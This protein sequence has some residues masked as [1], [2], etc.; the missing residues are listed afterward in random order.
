MNVPGR[1]QV[2]SAFDELAGRLDQAARVY[3]RRHRLPPE[4][5]DD[6]LQ[7]TL[8]AF[9]CKHEEIRDPEAWLRGTLRKR[10]QLYWR[11]RQRS[12]LTMVDRSVLEAL[13]TRDSGQEVEDVGR[14]L[15]RALDRIP[16]RCRRLLELR[17]RD[18]C[19]PRDAAKQLGYRP[20]GVY[21]IM[22]RCLAALTRGLVATG[23]MREGAG[24]P[25]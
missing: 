4:D 2:E 8:L 3:L 17:Y 23:F 18:D 21:K 1:P 15:D 22:A 12:L 10:C 25:S 19:D 16:V 13:A 9:L 14:D 20:S 5:A 7:E 6:I 24:A 11:R